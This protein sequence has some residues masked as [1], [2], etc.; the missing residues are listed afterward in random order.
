MKID[1]EKTKEFY[2]SL[3]YDELC[4]CDY[5]KN[6]YEKIKE[7]YP[8]IATCLSKFGI[9]IAKPYEI[10]SLEPEN[11]NLIYSVCQY[12]VF[13]NCED[14]FCEKVGDIKFK[15]SENYPNINI[16]D[17][18]FVLDIFGIKLTYRSK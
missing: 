12:I 2:N 16:E 18:H 10:S 4:N 15:K 5:C 3:G 8:E 7:T 14:D 6:Y 17:E 1:I 11:G 9:D 13:G